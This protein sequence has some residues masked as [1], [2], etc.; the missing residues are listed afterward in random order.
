MSRLRRLVLVGF[1]AAGKTTVGRLLAER[2]G[3][4]FLDLDEVIEQA[5][6]R[7]VP[8]IF[9]DEGEAVFRALEADAARA[10]LARDAVVIAPGGGW[11][12][13]AGGLDR[14]PEG[15]LAV[16]LRISVEEALE[17]SARGGEPGAR[18]PLLA[19]DDPL[20]R[21]RL[22]LA[23]REPLYR[24]AQ[25]WVDT[26]RRTPLQVVDEIVERVEAE[27]GPRGR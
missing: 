27:D 19:G 3:W 1:M 20:L 16:W 24:Q 12:S 23:A 13:G 10:A 22:L 15:T 21:A 17:R 8:A 25:V 4:S 14:L 7:S 18:R 5:E 2:L 26:T 9:R 11:V 6:G